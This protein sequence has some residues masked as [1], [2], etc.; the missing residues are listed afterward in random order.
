MSLG[1]FCPTPGEFDHHFLPR[2]RELDKKFA[3]VA[4]ISS[5]KKILPGVAGGGCTQLELTETLLDDDIKELVMSINA[6]SA[7]PEQYLFKI[8]WGSMPPDPLESLKNFFL[9][10]AWLQKFF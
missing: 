9:A 6:I 3:R 7:N 4:G 2:G 10:A 5:L 1:K 8:F